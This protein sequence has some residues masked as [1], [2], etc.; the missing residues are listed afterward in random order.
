[1]KT[2]KKNKIKKILCT[3][4]VIIGISVNLNFVSEMERLLYPI[5]NYL[6][7]TTAKAEEVEQVK[8]VLETESIRYQGENFWKAI[9]RMNT[10]QAGLEAYSIYLDYDQEKL[11]PVAIYSSKDTYD[12]DY[13]QYE[14]LKTNP[15]VNYAACHVNAQYAS[16]SGSVNKAGSI[17]FIA[18]FKAVSKTEDGFAEIWI[19][20]ESSFTKSDK[21]VN[22]KIIMSLDSITSVKVDFDDVKKEK[23]END[24]IGDSNREETSETV[25]STEGNQNNSMD[26]NN[27][28]D[29]NY[30]LEESSGGSKESEKIDNGKNAEDKKNKKEPNSLND[31]KND[32]EDIKDNGINSTEDKE[33]SEKIKTNT[34]A[35]NENKKGAKEI[36]VKKKQLKLNKTKATI[37]VGKTLKLK[38]K[39]TAKKVLW[40]SSKKRI[41]S[42]NKKG[43]VIAKKHGTVIIKAKVKGAKALKC[44]VLVKK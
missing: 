38:V 18:Y 13:Y 41:A 36:K 11:K 9:V 44:K 26:S 34:N 24:R 25:T 16:I 2:A 39:N 10:K 40:Y 22:K 23:Q 31:K 3:I 30:F 7:S 15:I 4:I 6:V 17:L 8:I 5:K 19:T 32:T 28:N 42:V 1:M 37:K 21:N 29:S 27:S 35:N 33:L 43:K 14:G 20:E 12:E